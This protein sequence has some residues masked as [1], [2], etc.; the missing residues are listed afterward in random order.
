MPLFESV[1]IS[2]FYLLRAV[3]VTTTRS[4][5]LCFDGHERLQ[6]PV[7]HKDIPL[8][9]L[10]MNSFKYKPLI[11]HLN[12]FQLGSTHLR[13]PQTTSN[14]NSPAS[15]LHSPSALGSG[16]SDLVLY[17]GPCSAA[18]CGSAGGRYTQIWNQS[19]HRGLSGNHY[20][21]VSNIILWELGTVV[22]GRNIGRACYATKHCYV[23]CHF[24]R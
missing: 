17:G 4:L 3:T 12:I 16:T 15:S 6:Y 8:H 9:L 1:Y 23:K 18:Y 5:K 11:P 21:K 20:G 24:L 14:P 10:E 19:S 7:P 22:Y 13:D 2:G